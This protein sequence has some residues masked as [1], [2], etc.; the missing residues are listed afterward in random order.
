MKIQ[1]CMWKACS[2]KFSEYILT[3]LD[4][5]KKFYDLDNCIVEKCPCTW[6]CKVWPTVVIDWHVE[7]HMDPA[8]ASKMM[9]DKKNHKTNNKRK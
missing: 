9:M 3:R 5:D 8:K 6:N 1:V 7:T 2:E 4:S